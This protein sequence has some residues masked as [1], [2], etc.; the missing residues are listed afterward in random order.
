V[1]S[2]ILLNNYQPSL[3]LAG[4]LNRGSPMFDLTKWFVMPKNSEGFKL[5]SG[6]TYGRDTHHLEGMNLT[7]NTKVYAYHTDTGKA[8]IFTKTPKGFPWDLKEYDNDFI[9]DSGTELGWDNP[10]DFKMQDIPIKMC[11]RFWD[12]DPTSYQFSQ[13]V[14]YHEYRNCIKTVPG[15]V[16]P[17]YFTLQFI[18]YM[19]YKGDIGSQP[20]ILLTYFWGDTKHREQ[21][22]LTFNFGWVKWTHSVRNNLSP[23]VI[24][25]VKD[26][27]VIHNKLVIG[28][29]PYKFDCDQ[30][31][32]G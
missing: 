31:R 25:Y 24:E 30:K 19:D 6:I 10:R 29:V 27:E 13:H 5:P 32:F 14:A 4:N 2:A 21:L 12:G 9:Y 16:G 7:N 26:S 23:N 3:H 17:A 8:L 28:S 18:P 1:F 15:D 20:T 11:P 22:F